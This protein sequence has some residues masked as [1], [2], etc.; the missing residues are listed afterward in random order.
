MP[1]LGLLVFYPRAILSGSVNRWARRT[2]RT[3]KNNLW[4]IKIDVSPMKIPITWYLKCVFLL[5]FFIFKYILT[6]VVRRLDV[7]YLGFLIFYPRTTFL[8][9]VKRRAR[10]D[11]GSRYIIDRIDMCDS[12]DFVFCVFALVIFKHILALLIVN[13][14][15][16][17][18]HILVRADF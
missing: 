14:K 17:Q 9:R 2:R 5:A 16:S 1:F 7:R 15:E 18:R 4:L 12:K 13:P 6:P 8:E 10:Q 3:R 11:S